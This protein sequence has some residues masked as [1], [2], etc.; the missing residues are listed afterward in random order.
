[1]VH[2]DLRPSFARLSGAADGVTLQLEITLVDVGAAC[3]PL[4]GHAIHLWHAD[5]NGHYSLYDLSDQ[6]HLRGVVVTDATGKARVTTVFPGCY[7][8]RWPHIHFEVFARLEAATDGDTALLTSQFALPAAATRMVY[9]D[10]RYVESLPN[11]GNVT[12]QGDMIFGDNT[13]EQITQQTVA[14]SADAAQG[15]KVT[16]VVGLKVRN[17]LRA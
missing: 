17:I 6:N 14:V 13:P 8:G 16:A 9:A 4:V 12:L 15:L 2:D 7:D 10:A 11:L 5:S 3:A 1:M